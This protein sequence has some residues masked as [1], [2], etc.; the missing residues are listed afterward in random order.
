MVTRVDDGRR[1]L[2]GSV[3]WF[4]LA[5]S[6]CSGLLRECYQTATGVGEIILL[7]LAKSINRFCI[8]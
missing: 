4:V 7:G 1:P 5:G 8:Y 3:E 6:C 2:P